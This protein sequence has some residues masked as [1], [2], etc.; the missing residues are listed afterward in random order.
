MRSQ[1]QGYCILPLAVMWA[2]A[3][4]AVSLPNLI[5]L[6]L[7]REFAGRFD[8]TLRTHHTA[9]LSPSL[10]QYTLGQVRELTLVGFGLRNWDALAR[11]LINLRHLHFKRGCLLTDHSGTFLQELPTEKLLTLTF[12]MMAIGTGI[13]DQMLESQASSLRR[14]ELHQWRLDEGTLEELS[15]S[16]ISHC[17]YLIIFRTK[18]M[19]SYVK[20]RD[21]RQISKDFVA[22]NRLRHHINAKRQQ[23]GLAVAFYSRPSSSKPRA[24]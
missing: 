15:D 13:F 4:L 17:R 21:S 8:D 10:L 20:V 14:L 16:V 19:C 3:L 24:P 7:C 1:V 12:R 18:N 2:R 11:S 9:G 22:L 6:K 23:E 5:R